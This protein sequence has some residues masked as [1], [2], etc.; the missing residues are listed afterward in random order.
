MNHW[1][2]IPHDFH[3]MHEPWFKE[4]CMSCG[5]RRYSRP[6]PDNVMTWPLEK[7]LANEN[8]LDGPAPTEPRNTE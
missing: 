1:L 6:H 5:G 8:G 3:P 7:L 4:L 2:V